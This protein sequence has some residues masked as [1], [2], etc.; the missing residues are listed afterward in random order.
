MWLA[1][2]KKAP[3]L[4]IFVAPSPYLYLITNSCKIQI[5]GL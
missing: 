5:Y 1:S 3:D 2:E 4:L